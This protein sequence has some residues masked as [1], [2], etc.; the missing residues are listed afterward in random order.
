[1]ARD[2]CRLVLM[3]AILATLATGCASTEQYAQ[4]ARAGTVYTAAVDRLLIAAGNTAID[5]TSEALLQDDE[6]SNQTRGNYEDL[7]QK[8]KD[9]LKVIFRLRDHA[10]LLARYFSLLD[11]LANSD[12]PDRAQQA[13]GG[14][15]DALNTSGGLLRKS[16]LV[17]DKEVF[18]SVTNISVG[19]IIRGLL[20][21]ELKERKK[22]IQIELK[23]QEELLKALNNDIQ[24]NLGQILSR[25]EERLVIKPLIE[26]RPVANPDGWIA[27]RRKIIT[28]ECKLEEL[29]T[30]SDA[31]R[32]LREAFEALVT[33]KLS[34]Q[35]I[36][37]LLT[38]LESILAV[39]ETINK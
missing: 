38:D 7:S 22:A 28:T 27:R 6:L 20:K 21:K 10:R 30:A 23:T 1:M 31:A 24:Q 8:N 34:L 4:F 17:P 5:K 37:I 11:E 39:A 19:F 18:T 36:N 3:L 32:K 12:A 14:V 26:A 25:Q 2:A 15:A 29:K 35:R 16:E 33:G 9:Y 13:I